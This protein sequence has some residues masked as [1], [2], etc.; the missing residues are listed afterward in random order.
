MKHINSILLKPTCILFVLIM[1]QSCD[2]EFSEIGTGIVGVPDFEIQNKNYPI[3]TYNKKIM[4]FESNRLEKDLLGYYHDPVFGGSSVSFVGQMAPSDYSPSFGENTVL[5]S[6]VLTI[7]YSSNSTTSDEVTSYELDSLY[8]S[9]PIK[10]S[11]YKND[12]LL[13]NF[14]PNAGINDTQKYYSNGSLDSGQLIEPSILESQLLYYN[15]SYFPSSESI[16]LKTYNEETEDFEVTSTLSPSLRLHLHN[17]PN[18]LSPPE[19]FWEELIFAREDDDVIGSQNSFYNYFRGLYFKA[20]AITE[21][22]GHI[23]QLDLLSSEA[24]LVIYYTYDQTLTVDGVEETSS[25]QSNYGLNFSG[26]RVNIFDNNFDPSI[27]QIINDT[28]TDLEGDD[29]LYLKGGEGSMAVIELFAEDDLGNSEEDYLNEFREIDGGQTTAKRLINE[30]FL[31]FYVEESLSSSDI[32]NRIYIYD[33][34]NNI[35]VADYFFDQTVNQTSADSKYNHLVPLSTETD[36][37]GVEH[38]KYK[39]RLTGHINNIVLEDST[40]VK[41]GL[42]VSSNV[43]SVSSR[44]LQDVNEI[45]GIPSGTVLSPKSVIIHGNNSQN[46]IK[47]PK[48]NIY[49]TESNN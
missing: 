33:L 6:V 37:E 35:P 15:G 44:K 12:F 49:Y 25:V 27:L 14:D 2:N 16:E 43:G 28:S 11:I 39:V 32:P 17:N 3:K 9:N 23:M 47:S 20:E 1:N 29:Y 42:V 18:N 36:S 4:P 40:N 34:D 46:S 41:L 22:E 48:L 8:G 5:D 10:L 7:P 45:K 30:A 19:G 24:N 31:E 26:N 38:K 21:T 13:R